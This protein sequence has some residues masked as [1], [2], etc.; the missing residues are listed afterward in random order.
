MVYLR[1]VAGDQSL[2]TISF[3]N[4]PAQR[5]LVFRSHLGLERPGC[6]DRV[7]ISS[8]NGVLQVGEQPG[9]LVES[10]ELLPGLGRYVGPGF[11][12]VGEALGRSLDVA[13][14]DTL[15][16]GQEAVMLPDV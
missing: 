1:H 6:R 7:P 2:Q 13:I 11:A 8:G 15:N 4:Q 5:L 9:N 10:D 16:S 14:S 3:G 12:Q